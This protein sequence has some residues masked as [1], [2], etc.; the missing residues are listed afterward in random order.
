MTILDGKT[1][2]WMIGPMIKF[3]L[4]LRRLKLGL[5]VKIN[6]EDHWVHFR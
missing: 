6:T 5:K 3:F 1:L 4:I 2:V